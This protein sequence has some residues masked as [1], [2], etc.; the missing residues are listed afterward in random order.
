M[1]KLSLTLLALSIS[2]LT[3]AEEI[4]GQ[5]SINPMVGYQLMDIDRNLDDDTLLGLGIEHRFNSTWGSELKYLQGSMDNS[6]STTND[7]DVKHLIL[8]AMYYIDPNSGSKFSP[9]LAAGIGH[10]EYDY[11]TSGKNQETTTTFGTGFKYAFSDR[12]S[13][14]VDMRWIHGHDDSTNDSLVTVGLNYAF[15]AKSTPVKAVAPKPVVIGDVDKDGVNDH[16]DKCNNTPIGASVSSNGCE[17]DSDNDGVVNSKDSCPATKAG[18]KVD[19]KGC[20]EKLAH[21][22]TIS[23]NVNFATG[24]DTLTN[25]F[26]AEIEKVADFMR[27]YN[28]VTGVIEGHTDSSGA[29]AF[30][31]NLS[32]LRAESV[33]D[34]L[35]KKFGIDAKRLS[36]KGFGEDRPI[37]SN[38]TAE[39]RK[40]NRRVSAIFNAQVMK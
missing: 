31:Q 32:Q 38:E 17:L 15:G 23:L 10:A 37:A 21:T 4:D 3:I 39:G 30:N 11:D 22:E 26:M 36:A 12:W 40:Q 16:N 5:W 33:V 18:A 19:S 7:A 1:K 28:S 34:V 6:S 24:S 8:E 27:K 2:G 35:V 14:K 25:N 20:A 29:S 13:S 9:Y